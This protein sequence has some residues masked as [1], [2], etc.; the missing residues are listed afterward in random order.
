MPVSGVMGGKL[1]LAALALVA[2]TPAAHALAPLYDPVVLNI[3]VNCQWQQS[4]ERRQRKALKSARS[5]I[6]RS[7][8]PLWKIHL[9]NRNASRGTA[10][11]DWVGFNACIRNTQLPAPRSRRR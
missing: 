8:P 5:F 6:A 9:C 3:G 1:A 4:C 11:I 2:V 7:N 10:R